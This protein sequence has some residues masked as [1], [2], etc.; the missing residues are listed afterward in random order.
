MIY[1]FCGPSGSGKDTSAIILERLLRERYPDKPVVSLAFGRALKEI[2]SDLCSLFLNEDYSPDDMNRLSFKET[3]IPN[4]VIF[5]ENQP[6]LLKIRTL[7]QRVGT[8]ILRKYL[9]DDIFAQTIAK[10]I[11]PEHITLITD[12]RFPN[13]L[14]I[15][16]SLGIPYKTVYV[17]RGLTHD[18]HQSESYYNILPKD[19]ILNNNHSLES[20]ENQIRLILE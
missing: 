3:E 14:E 20:L 4:H 19:Y 12:L 13:E 2:V 15:I 6:Q 11:N 18:S 17:N 1:L 16:K 7:L 10:K 9:G 8:D 5:L